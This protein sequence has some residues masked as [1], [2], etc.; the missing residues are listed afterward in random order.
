MAA[1][2]IPL[3]LELL[4]VVLFLLCPRSAF[5]VMRCASS[6]CRADDPMTTAW[7][8]PPLVTDAKYNGA[9]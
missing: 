3:A 6:R 4:P 9:Q 7:D 8:D 1:L 2:H 5:P